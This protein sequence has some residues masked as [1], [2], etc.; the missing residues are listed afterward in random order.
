[1]TTVVLCG[2]PDEKR[3]LTNA[4]K[5]GTLILSGTDKLNLLKLIPA[6]CTRIVCM[7]L[8]GGL[9]PDL[10]VPDVVLAT[11]VVDHAGHVEYADPGWNFRA[12]AAA[13]DADI[14][15]HMVPYYSSG[16]FDEADTS[17]QRAAMFKKYGAHAI[18]DETRYVVAEATRRNIPFNVVRPLSDDWSETLPLSATGAIM[19]KDGSANIDFL[20]RSLG[21]DQGQDSVSLFRVA[22]DYGRSLDALEKVAKALSNL[23]E[24]N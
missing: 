19:N 12:V 3:V 15:L 6:S 1:M 22:I 11:S 10:S 8:C 18:D 21:Q 2:M 24:G 17:G 7:G 16:L 4:F 13:T 23:I 20:L 14:K 9:S 5:P